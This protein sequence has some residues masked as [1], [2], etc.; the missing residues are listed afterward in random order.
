M[1]SKNPKKFF[2]VYVITLVILGSFTTGIFVGRSNLVQQNVDRQNNILKNKNSDN[3][4]EVDFNL[5]WDAWELLEKKYIE[6]P[7]DYEKMLYGAIDGMVSSLD[8]PYTSFMDPE[9]AEEFKEEIDGNFEGIGAEI[10]IKNNLLTIIAPL[11]DSPAKKAGLRA[12]DIILE[13]DGKNTAEM[14]LIEAVYLIR[15]EK[16]T[17]VKLNIGRKSEDAKEYIIT[18]ASIEVKSVEWKKIKSREKNDIAYIELSY[19]GEDTA[20]DLKMISSEIL[21]AKPKGIIL[22]L[23]NNTGGYLETSIDVAS[24]FMKKGETVTY[25]V[26]TEEGENKKEYKTDG[27]DRLSSIPL[28]ILVNNGS[29][30]ASEILAGALNENL[31]I[32]LVGETTY[33]KGSVQQLEYLDD[34]SSLRITI[35]KWLTPNEKNINQEGIEPTHKV[36]L[37][38]EDYNNDRD[39]QLEKAKELIDNK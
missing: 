17:D 35:A 25:Q 8:D 22:D 23:R 20:N 1:S 33:G 31:S 28:V 5:F 26:S 11:S 15:G 37:T 39:P 36:E 6:R 29:A 14:S 30:S 16:G 13:I 19:F 10:G 12:R 27:G 34:G 7:L 21:K 38:E 4:D 32:P 3:T 9:K 2:L 24:I 18:R